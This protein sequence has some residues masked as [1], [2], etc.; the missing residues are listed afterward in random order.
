[1]RRLTGEHLVQ[2]ARE[3]VNVGAAGDLL[4]RRRLFGRHVVRRSERE[5]GLGH[6]AARRR[7]D[8]ERDAEVH[9]HRAPV[10]QQN[11]LGLYVAMDHALPMRVVERVGHFAR[12]ADRFVDAELRLAVELL[13]NRL[14]LDV[15]H[16]VKRQSVGRA[17]I[18]EG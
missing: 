9:H 13:T 5:A 16:D 18:E 15:G 17:G 11:V 4:L 3:R 14:A 8:G 12:D 10:V 6:P 1:M 7:G 2:H